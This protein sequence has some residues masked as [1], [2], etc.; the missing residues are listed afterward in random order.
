MNALTKNKG[1]YYIFIDEV[2]H[3][4]KFEEAIASVRV[5]YPCSLFVTGS[6]SKLLDGELQ[7]RLTGRAKDFSMGPFTY[8]EAAAFK[9][10]NGLPILEGDFDDYLQWGGMPQRYEE[11]DE[12]GLVD[13]FQGLYR[14]IIKKDVFSSQKRINRTEFEK[15][16]G[17]AMVS[18]GRLFY[19]CCQDALFW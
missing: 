3:I 15:A 10:A 1:K 5:S 8:A 2:Q 12:S 19:Q 14:S 9:R 4:T 11:V 18:S 6:N 16:A 7:D 17:Y 13:Y